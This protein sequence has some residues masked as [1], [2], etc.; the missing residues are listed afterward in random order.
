MHPRASSVHTPAR[1]SPAVPSPLLLD[2]FQNH[3]SF[4]NTDSNPG[5][6]D[7]YDASLWH[8][9][10]S[11]SVH[12]RAR[13]DAF[14]RLLFG[15]VNRACNLG[16][17]PYSTLFAR[18]M[19]DFNRAKSCCVAWQRA[20]SINVRTQFYPKPL[21][22]LITFRNNVAILRSNCSYSRQDV[23][24]TL[25]SISQLDTPTPESDRP[26]IRASNGIIAII[27]QHILDA[28]AFVAC[29]DAV[30]IHSRDKHLS[31]NESHTAEDSWVAVI[32]LDNGEEWD[33][34]QDDEE[35]YEYESWHQQ[36]GDEPAEDIQEDIEVSDVVCAASPLL[37]PNENGIIVLDD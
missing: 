3:R 35:W 33:Q 31:L 36:H 17:T 7:P 11:L 23:V 34:G 20:K 26:V 1:H 18:L 27:G 12:V 21:D 19:Y 4:D 8:P 24:T 25:T 2:S 13:D 29:L 5:P 14:E 16:A 32:P 9:E 22:H 6:V 37:V 28:E 15:K 30:I 10:S